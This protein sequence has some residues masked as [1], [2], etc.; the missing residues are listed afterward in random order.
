MK[1]WQ[2]GLKADLV[3]PRALVNSGSRMDDLIVDWNESHRFLIPSSVRTGSRPATRP[4]VGGNAG[5]AL[6]SPPS[7]ATP[8]ATRRQKGTGQK[9]KRARARIGRS[10]AVVIGR[11]AVPV[12]EETDVDLD[13]RSGGD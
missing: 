12:E 6:T 1:A 5:T 4:T 13:K 11:S 9:T 2:G 8:T 7:G 10:S 3:T